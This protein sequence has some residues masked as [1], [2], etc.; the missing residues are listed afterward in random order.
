MKA[1]LALVFLV[2]GV[3]PVFA[4]EEGPKLDTPHYR[5]D[6]STIRKGAT[7]FATHCLSCHGLKHIRYQRLQSDLG[8]DAA[9]IEKDIM[10][11][12]GAEM[13]EGMTV[14][15]RPEDAKKWFG[16]APPDLTL[17]ARYRGVDWIYTYLKSFYYDSSRPSGWNNHVFNNVAMPNV[18]EPLQGIKAADGST[19]RSGSVSPQEFDQDVEYITAWLQYT[20]DPSQL[21]RRSI[22]P[23]AI[24]FLVVFTLLAYALKRVYWRRVH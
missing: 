2:V 18:L 6:R 5:F 16:A 24:G 15:M 3:A 4:V 21:T 14:T 9:K 1:A 12:D 11:P 10:L 13:N 20:G 8:I 19:I 17:E 23:W 7:L 22:G